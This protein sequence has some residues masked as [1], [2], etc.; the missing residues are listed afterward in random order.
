MQTNLEKK[1][2]NAPAQGKTEEQWRQENEAREKALTDADW[3]K[4]DEA[5]K[6]LDAE[7]RKLAV[8]T[9][10][11]R[12]AFMAEVLGSAAQ[13]QETFRRPVVEKKL[14]VSE[15]IALA[16]KG[17]KANVPLARRPHGSGFSENRDNNKQP[18]QPHPALL[19][20]G[21]LR[22]MVSAHKKG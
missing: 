7:T 5:A 22:D 8:S 2:D 12:A 17:E 15:Q 3:T 11:G 14:S 6:A 18:A 13:T 1:A 20:T 9:E 19:R 4:L 16:L 10:E 21:S